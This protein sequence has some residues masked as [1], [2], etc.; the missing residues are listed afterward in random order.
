MELTVLA[1]VLSLPGHSLPHTYRGFVIITHRY[2]TTVPTSA[3]GGAENWNV[4]LVESF[5]SRHDPISVILI[6]EI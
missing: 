1:E 2:R 5:K 3:S 4:E 6:T